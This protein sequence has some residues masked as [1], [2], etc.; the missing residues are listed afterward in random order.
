MTR[1][2]LPLAI[3]LSLA[4]SAVFAASPPSRPGIDAPELAA[5]GSHAV[6]Y[7]TLTLIQPQQAN[8]ELFDAKTGAIP[9]TDR[10]L[11]IDIWYPAA[12]SKRAKPVTYS[13]EFRGEP[14]RPA[15]AFTVPGLAIKNAKPEGSGHPLVI[16]SHGY[17]NTPI[18][19]TWLTENLASKGYV[20]A[21]IYHQDPDPDRSTAVVRSAPFLRRPLD[22][23]YVARTLPALLGE[24]IDASKIGLIGY[25]MGGYGVVTAGGATLDANGPTIR[26]G[27]G[28]GQ[29]VAKIAKGG[30]D[31]ALS[32]V[33]GVKA[34]V[35]MAPAGGS[36]GAWNA[37]GLAN[38]KAPVLLIAGDHDQTVDYTTG[39]KAI[40]GGAV[41]SDRYLLT[42]HEAGHSVGLGP[43]P[44]EMMGQL[45]DQDW[46]ADPIWRTDRINA[47]NLHFITAFLNRALNGKSDL[48]SYLNVA[49]IASDDGVWA[50]DPKAPYGAYS[51]ATN[52]V[53]VWKGFQRR[54]ARGLELRHAAP[55]P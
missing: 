31:E 35:A 5:L 51:T 48:D 54:H 4:S 20:V 50:Y 3:I 9:K 38:I 41:N 45:W 2:F 44:E 28:P 42:F 33:A 14:P 15:A 34:I 29:E 49:T 53:T 18:G 12:T 22:I 16:V 27:G 10:T 43:V 6:G 55:M 46:F 40:F 23:G 39:A 8:L 36:M 32:K 7:K 13:S 19:M 11:R 17:S 21:A 52:G 1:P 26:F 47:I 37:E 30:A 24:Q 25:S